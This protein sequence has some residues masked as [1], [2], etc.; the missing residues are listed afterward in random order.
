[1]QTTNY[2]LS[3]RNNVA[4]TPRDNR[5]DRVLLLR[6]VEENEV[7]LRERYRKTTREKEIQKILD[8]FYSFHICFDDDDDDDQDERNNDTVS[9]RCC[10][11]CFLDDGLRFSE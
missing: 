6:R 8:S 11:C 7:S 3:N 5:G 4:L 10:C 2:H 1:M 9:C